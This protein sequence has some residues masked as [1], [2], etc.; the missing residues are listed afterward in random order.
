MSKAWTKCLRDVGEMRSLLAS[1]GASA[2]RSRTMNLL[3]KLHMMLSS[4]CYRYLVY[5][6][7]RNS[8]NRKLMP[9]S[10]VIVNNKHAYAC[11]RYSALTTH[12]QTP[13]QLFR[14]QC[15]FV[16][17]LAI[18]FVMKIPYHSLVT[19]ERRYEAVKQFLGCAQKLAS[20]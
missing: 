8:R 16:E 6:L 11:L 18:H 9:D 2:A 15:R 20:S 10:A 1:S 14:V 13:L 5:P 17:N 12:L 3:M 19:K 7:T 4:S